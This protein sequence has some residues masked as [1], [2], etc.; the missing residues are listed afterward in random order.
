MKASGI[1]VAIMALMCACSDTRLYEDYKDFDNRYWVVTD[2]PSFEFAVDDTVSSYGLYCNLRNAESY[3]FSDFRFTYT[4]TDSTGAVYEKKLVTQYL[5][6]QKSGKPF[7]ESGLGDIYDHQFPLLQKFKFTK[8]G[9]YAVKFEQFMRK[10][11]LD[12]ILAVGLR[13]EKTP[14]D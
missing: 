14:V 11:S 6:D 12:G 5:F 13:V 1:L 8:P 2:Q 3:P 10:D 7:G 4:L 9:V